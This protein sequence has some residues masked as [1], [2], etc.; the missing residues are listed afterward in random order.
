[1]GLIVAG[2]LG[3]LGFLARLDVWAEGVLVAGGLDGFPK[4]LPTWIVWGAT[5]LIACGLS[6][7]MLGV[8]CVWRRLV[9]WISTLAL[10]IFWA[11]VLGLAAHA[12]TIAAPLVAALWSGICALVYAHNHRM[13]VDE[14][15]PTPA[16]AQS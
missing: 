7:A 12:P 11:P 3:A 2:G 10:V 9:L 15:L 5:V 16:D 8:P 4:S 1:M 13:P 14:P 6:A